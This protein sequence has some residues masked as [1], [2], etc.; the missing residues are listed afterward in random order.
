MAKG[1]SSRQF[2]TVFVSLIISFAVKAPRPMSSRWRPPLAGAASR[3]LSN[4]MFI[5]SAQVNASEVLV[6]RNDE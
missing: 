1:T 6:M 5:V 4:V 3:N 2:V